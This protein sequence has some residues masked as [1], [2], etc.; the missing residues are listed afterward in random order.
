MSVVCKAECDLPQPLE[1]WQRRVDMLTGIGLLQVL[2]VFSNFIDAKVLYGPAEG[3]HVG[4]ALSDICTGTA[5]EV[6]CR[7][8]PGVFDD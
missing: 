6:L 2:T 8:N 1:V 3:C 5:Y 7:A 4:I